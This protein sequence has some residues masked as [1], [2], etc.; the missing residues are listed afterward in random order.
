MLTLCSFSACPYS[1]MLDGMFSHSSTHHEH[2]R[3]AVIE[4]L[5]FF[6]TGLSNIISV[7]CVFTVRTI[8]IEDIPLS[9]KEVKLELNL[10]S[11][12]VN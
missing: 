8:H 4:F 6:F 7:S 1:L 2:R 11:C 5:I 3:I 12:D 10:H 9:S